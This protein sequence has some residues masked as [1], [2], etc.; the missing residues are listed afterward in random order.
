MSDDKKLQFVNLFKIIS[1]YYGAEDLTK[2]ML[3]IYF[4]ALADFSIDEIKCALSQHM[5]INEKSGSFF[6]KISDI[7]RFLDVGIPTADQVI[8]DA[9][10]KSTPFGVLANRFITQFDLDRRDDRYLKG[11]ALEVL[12][13]YDE[14]KSLFNENKIGKNTLEMFERNNLKLDAHFQK[15]GQLKPEVVVRIENGNS[16]PKR[17]LK[18]VNS[19]S[20]LVSQ[21]LVTAR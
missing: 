21:S 10:S 20:N 14:W 16:K 3:R 4:T 12:N 7:K 18:L 8:A 19:I 17:N 6:P 9:R 1:R 2:D 13:K 11:R 15:S 5:S